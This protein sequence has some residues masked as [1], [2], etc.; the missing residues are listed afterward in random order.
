MFITRVSVFS[1]ELS[2]ATRYSTTCVGV[3]PLTFSVCR[4]LE[5]KSELMLMR[6]ATVISYAG[7]LG[8]SSV[9]SAKTHSL[10]VHRSLRS[11]KITKK[12]LF[13]ANYPDNAFYRKH[14]KFRQNSLS[15]CVSQPKIAKK[16]TRALYFWISKSFKV[17][18]IDTTGK[19]VSMLVMISSKSVSICNHSYARLVDS[20][21]NNNFLTMKM[22]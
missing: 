20:N 4:K 17:I 11:P 15:K 14:V 10:N 21:T 6:R 16:I 18:D 12:P 19:L 9:I 5:K 1:W 3:S 2:I 8:L 13:F 22:L 7:C